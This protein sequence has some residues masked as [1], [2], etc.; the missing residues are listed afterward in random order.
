M[1]DRANKFCKY[2]PCH[3]GLEDCTFCYCPLYPCKNEKRGEYISGK[4]KNKI[5]SCMNCNW[6]HKKKTVDKIFKM[7]KVNMREEE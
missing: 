2:Y 7:I 1:I 4:T 3:D 6:I 5:W